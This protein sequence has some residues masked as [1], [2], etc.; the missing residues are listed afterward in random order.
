MVVILID[1]LIFLTPHLNFE[2]TD[3]M[4][5]NSF[6]E[7]ASVSLIK[8]F[9]QPSGAITLILVL[10]LFLTLI[11][12]VKITKIFFGPLRQKI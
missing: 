6:H 7:E 8:L 12:V 9:N 3:I 1:P 11:A 2:I 5:I 4:Q 10:Y